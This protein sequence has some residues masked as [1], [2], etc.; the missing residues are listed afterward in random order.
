MCGWLV[1]ARKT[2]YWHTVH[3]WIR[4]FHS[5]TSCARTRRTHSHRHARTA[6]QS[7]L[8]SHS[9]IASSRTIF[10][11]LFFLPLA[12]YCLVL[13]AICCVNLS[14]RF[15]FTRR[16]ARLGN[17]IVFKTKN[18]IAQNGRKTLKNT[19]IVE[20]VYVCTQCSLHLNY[21]VVVLV[22]RVH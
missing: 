9:A 12:F 19:S 3:S 5:R 8:N 18:R 13:T 7:V 22:L 21:I 6:H 1:G 15:V 4:R 17:S 2:S 14:L 16:F 10:F 20:R 11:S